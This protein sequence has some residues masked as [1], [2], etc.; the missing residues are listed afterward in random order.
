MISS[1]AELPR[2]VISSPRKASQR[3]PRISTLRQRGVSKDVEINGRLPHLFHK[4]RRVMHGIALGTGVKQDDEC[5]RVQVNAPLLHFSY[6]L[7]T[8]LAHLS[9]TR[10]FFDN[11]GVSHCAT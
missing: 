7:N 11:D 5:H 9:M 8:S 4:R 3:H 1:G 2:L 6:M 10:P